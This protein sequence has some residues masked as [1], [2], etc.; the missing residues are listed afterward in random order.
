MAGI[1]LSAP[2][3]GGLGLRPPSP[4]S[5]ARLAACGPRVK[6]DFRPFT[7]V[8]FTASRCLCWEGVERKPW[9][10]VQGCRARVP[11][12]PHPGRL[13]LTQAPHS[14]GQEGTRPPWP[15]SPSEQ[16]AGLCTLVPMWLQASPRRRAGVAH[17]LRCPAATVGV[18]APWPPTPT[19][20][21]LTP[22]QPAGKAGSVGLALTLGSEQLGAG[23][24]A[25]GHQLPGGQ[26]WGGHVLSAPPARAPLPL[27]WSCR[28]CL[29]SD[30][31]APPSLPAFLCCPPCPPV[32][33]TSPRSWALQLSHTCPPLQPFVRSAHHQAGQPLHPPSGT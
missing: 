7:S 13:T 18:S 32:G 9:R 4:G 20:H 22:A 29:P 19:A 8:F 16:K 15:E 28:A 2:S 10:G 5:S 23:G 26:Q 14:A 17:R 21:A 12:H 33:W 25:G 24:P 27:P 6:V 30:S 11:R 1:E 3:A 31:H